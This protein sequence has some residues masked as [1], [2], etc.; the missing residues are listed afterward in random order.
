MNPQKL[1][2]RMREKKASDT[3]F[4]YSTWLKSYRNSPFAGQM[5]NDTFYDNH[6]LLV[7]KIL[8]KPTTKVLVLC[9]DGDEDHLYGYCVVEV[10]GNSVE[11]VHYCYV[12][13]TYRKMG[14]AK[15]L[16][17]A[18]SGAFASTQSS[19]CSHANTNFKILSKKFNLVYNPYLL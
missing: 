15:A 12:K 3:S 6:K 16:L 11:V 14:F 9:E 8:S 13:Y 7:E 19:L 18:A 2:I 10:I 4:I 5:S 17:T 1:P